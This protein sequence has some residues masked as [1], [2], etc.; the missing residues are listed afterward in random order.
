ME[1]DRYQHNKT[2]FII[3]I[4]SLVAGLSLFLFA[5]FILPNL[6][7]KL[8]YNV[9][10]FIYIWSEDLKQH[11]NFTDVGANTVVFL[12]FFLPAIL[13]TLIAYLTSNSIENELYGFTTTESDLRKKAVK[14]SSREGL[15][16][17][18]QILIFIVLVISGVYTL[19]W[20]L[21]V[22]PPT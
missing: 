10:S 20:L 3:S 8:N 9:P 12:I 11:Y 16:V 1:H 13:A 4:I 15:L 22:P 14:N 6:I 5:L 17:I 19:H 2:L 21:S 18:V 7:W